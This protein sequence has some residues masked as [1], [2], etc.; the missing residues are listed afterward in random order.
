MEPKAQ[1]TLARDAKGPIAPA[2]PLS[3]DLRAVVDAVSAWPEVVATTHWH[4]ADHTRV[5]GVDFY[6]D[7]EEL[8]HL[9]LEG[10]I[11]LATTPDLAAEL[12]A[13]GSATPFRYARGW[14]QANVDHLGVDRAV[15]LFRRNYDRLRSSEPSEIR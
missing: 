10:S 6:V 14:T 8:G 7:A 2:P 4:F 3:G 13:E 5:D 15:A 12:I 9:H 11:H 1:A